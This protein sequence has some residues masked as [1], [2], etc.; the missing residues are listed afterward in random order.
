MK[1]LMALALLLVG[2]TGFA[3]EKISK[4][5]RKARRT[6]MTKLSPEQKN[7]LRLK[8]LTLE[9]DLNAS[10]QKEMAKIIAEQQ[11]KREAMKV[12]MKAKRDTTKKPTSDELFVMKNK[13]LDDKIAE[14]QRLKK[15]LTPEQLEKWDNLK[16]ERKRNFQK[17]AKN[18]KA[19]KLQQKQE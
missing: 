1:K 8:E 4:E 17:G 14:K 16:K 18:F 2:M 10:Q 11:T 7:Q 3:Q 12:E 9:L 6:E 19:K 5:D 13:M 15:V